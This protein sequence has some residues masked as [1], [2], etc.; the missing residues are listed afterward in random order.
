[1]E[2]V[3][4]NLLSNDTN[5]SRVL[6]E[7]DKFKY[8]PSGI[9]RVILDHLRDITDGT[10]DIVDPT[11]PFVFLLEASA[12][13]TA[14]FIIQNEVSTR[15]QYP[16]TAQTYEDIYIHMSDKDY[17][18]RFAI[19]AQ[20]KFS[21][22]IKKDELLDK[23]ENDALKVPSSNFS[24][25]TIPGNT[26]FK[27]ADTVFSLQYPVDIKRFDHGGFQII[28]N[29]DKVSPLFSLS[30]NNVDWEFRTS[31]Q[32]REEWLYMEV[33]VHQF[34]IDS[35]ISAVSVTNGFNETYSFDNQFYYARVYNK[36]T[37]TGG[38]W[39]E[40]KTTHT[41][42]VYDI[43]TPTVVLKVVDK[44]L[45][46]TIPQIYLNTNQITGSIRVD[47]YDTLG[48]INM[49][50][51]NYLPST[52]ETDWRVIDSNDA[53]K[54]NSAI[55]SI[56][57]VFTYSN[58]TVIGGKDSIKF[59]D[60]RTKVIN[61]AIGN[62]D[63]PITNVQIES[64]L[65][66]KGYSIIKNVDVVTNRIFLATRSMPDPIDDRI[67]TNGNAS[68]ETFIMDMSV[69]NK[70]FFDNGSRL[71]LTPDIIYL[72]DNEVITITNQ[73][74]DDDISKSYPGDFITK[75]EENENKA[76]ILNSKKYLYSPFFYV[77]DASVDEF[78][79][80]PYR[81]DNPVVKSTSFIAQNQ[82]SLIDIATDRYKIELNRIVDS[83]IESGYKLS[84]TTKS[85]D[86]AKKL[87][88]SLIN[89][90]LSFVPK[91]ETNRV[92]LNSLSVASGVGTTASPYRNEDNEIVFEF[93]LSTRLDIDE[94]DTLYFSNFKLVNHSVIVG[95][96]LSTL[97]DLT[98]SICP[99]ISQGWTPD[100]SI[101]DNIIN[102]TILPE[103]TVGVTHEKLNVEFGIP[104]K[105]LWSRSRSVASAEPY[106]KQGSD[107]YKIYE[108]DVYEIDNVTGSIFTIDN[109]QIR[110]R[111]LHPKNTPVLDNHG[112]QVYEY[113]AG[114]P[115]RDSKGNPIPKSY[116]TVLRQIDMLFLDASYYYATDEATV[117]YRNLMVN[118]IVNWLM[119]DIADMSNRLLEQTR[120]YFYPKTNIGNI[121]VLVDNGLV[122][123]IDA[124]QRLTVKLYVSALV[125][126][127]D[128]L[129]KTLTRATIRT[130][131][132]L[133]K[134]SVISISNI[135]IELKNL[136]GNDVINIDISGL[137]GE[138]NNFSTISIL[139]EGDTCSIKKKLVSLSNNTLSVE[140]DINIV[141]FKHEMETV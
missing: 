53:D 113:R 99:P 37:S 6:R 57:T 39:I 104:L 46:V 8:N 100:T 22:L 121:N 28:Y 66:N 107:K 27:V 31:T 79:V 95:A 3:Y 55:N 96:D 114:D 120:I 47:I 93:T 134:Q 102:K 60:L 89:A 84:V 129:R 12:V 109:G 14:N 112:A 5:V 81:L 131:D 20:T 25:L 98:Y 45:T 128:A 139:N 76:R 33:D 118:S 11:N 69:I 19:P 15:K 80:R 83:S 40:L 106:L 94:D 26:E 50:L 61:N 119:V 133:L 16:A 30:T 85:N 82:T 59:E 123:G 21:I 63:L 117:N 73:A 29:T 51:E 68:I 48:K 110:Y 64:A 44:L 97:F 41:D 78:E 116:N 108:E 115:V 70:K 127:N 111:L 101:I 90:Q 67:L 4:T 38:K 65:S 7:L 137:G 52:F 36:S 42:Q 92:Y 10:V 17:I 54:Y 56:R 136:Y 58:R 9:Q 125:F 72:S 122:T 32:T 77:L 24:K 62:H 140:E 91:N 135:L 87:D 132:V 103:Y 86:N 124:S 13:N 23:F 35:T 43:Y 126:S 141:F 88:I 138:E 18:D 71:T 75:K 130:L 34:K 74:F 105:T 49:I 2:Q 1:M